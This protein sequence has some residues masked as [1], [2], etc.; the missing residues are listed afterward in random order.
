MTAEAKLMHGVDMAALG[1]TGQE[2]EH[3][4][5]FLLVADEPPTLIGKNEGADP[6]ERLFR[7]EKK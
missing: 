1:G 2:I 3:A 6:V 5:S 4:T 7:I